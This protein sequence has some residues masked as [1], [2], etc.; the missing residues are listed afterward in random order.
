MNSKSKVTLNFG[1]FLLKGCSALYI[2]ILVANYLDVSTFA[3]WSIFFS[4]T[5]LLSVSDLGIGQYV[6]TTFSSSKLSTHEKSEQFNQSLFML[7]VV[8]LFLMALSSFGL[9]WFRKLSGYYLLLFFSL[10]IRV[11]ITPYAAYLQSKDKLHEKKIVEAFS[12]ILVLLVISFLVDRKVKF[13]MILLVFNCAI[14]F[15][16]GLIILRAKY[17]SCPMLN[18]SKFI[19]NRQVLKNSAPYLANN[20]SNL[21]IYAGFITFSSLLLNVKQLAILSILH[22][23]LFSYGYQIYDLFFRIAQLR[24]IERQFFK[25]AQKVFVMS[26]MFGVVLILILG[27]IFYSTVYKNYQIDFKELMSFTVFSFLEFYSLLLIFQIQICPKLSQN[28]L[29]LSLFKTVTFGIT[30]VI[31]RLSSHYSLTQYIGFLSFA[32]FMT[33]ARAQ[34]IISRTFHD[35]L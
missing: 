4:I 19:F 20:S 31:Y 3:E 6:L 30:L 27:D 1:A 13:E 14:T 25:K 9:L 22:A 32:S 5:M 24:F 10:F 15:C 23:T 35:S 8:S 12:Y 7:L 11:P 29:G 2:N 21:I 17:W 16:Q 18:A 34:N 33:V 26:V 28:L